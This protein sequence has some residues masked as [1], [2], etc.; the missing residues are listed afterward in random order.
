LA[1]SSYPKAPP[2]PNATDAAQQHALDQWWAGDDPAGRMVAKITVP[3]LLADGTA[4]QLDP[5]VNSRL[6]ARL[7]PQATLKLYPD[8]GHA[9]LYQDYTG[10]TTQV[11]SFL[12][13]AN[14]H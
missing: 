3:T 14:S 8:A 5:V 11:N 12:S 10:V 2:A 13:Q 9:F 4:D 6:L 1:I 7:I